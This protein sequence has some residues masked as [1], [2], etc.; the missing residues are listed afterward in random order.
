M[1]AA[2]ASTKGV[3]IEALALSMA[4][5][6]PARTQASTVAVIMSRNSQ[7]VLTRFRGHLNFG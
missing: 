3:L 5:N 1:F 7:L 4:A 6:R 2:H